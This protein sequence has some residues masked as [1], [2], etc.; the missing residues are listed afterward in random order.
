[1]TATTAKFEIPAD[2]RQAIVDYKSTL[3]ARLAENASCLKSAQDDLAQ[4]LTTEETLT[5]QIAMLQSTVRH[6]DETGV[7]NLSNLET[8]LRVLR[9]A[10]ASAVTVLDNAEAL[11]VTLDAQGLLSDLRSFY[12]AEL[13]GFIGEQMRPFFRLGHT[14]EHAVRNT[15]AFISAHG[16]Q[17]FIT[18][19]ANVKATPSAV[20]AVYEILDRALAGSACLGFD[21]PTPA[22]KEENAT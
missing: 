21:A 12:L 19:N 10:I 14:L 3:E 4:L 2:L 7:A 13:P 9:N 20:Q 15:D 17:N 6:D 11:E 1:M 22:Q 16:L 5:G 18:W 8:R